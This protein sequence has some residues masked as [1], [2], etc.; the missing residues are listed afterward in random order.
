MK[1]KNPPLFH[2][3]VVF[4][5]L[6]DDSNVLEKFAQCNNCGI[7]HRVYDIC[8]SELTKKEAHITIQSI[9]DISLSLPSDLTSILV[10]YKCDVS[11]WEQ[12]QFI[13]E[14]ERWGE[15]SIVARE[16]EDGTVSG[17]RLVIEG[18]TKFRIEPISYTEVI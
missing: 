6:D 17:K 13:Y 5:I 18:P 14:N 16:N 11:V 15:F 10:S 7:V 1:N 9:D 12:V 8:K 4:S 3:F 2:S